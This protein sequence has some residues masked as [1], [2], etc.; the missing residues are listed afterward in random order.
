LEDRTVA[1]NDPDIASQPVPGV[2]AI[3]ASA[4]GVEALQRFARGLRADYPAPIL[5]VQH[6]GPHPSIL[7]EL[8]TRAG[9]PAARH[10]IDGERLQPARIYVAPPDHHMI[11]SN[12]RVRLSHGPKENHTRPAIDPLF[13]SVA[14]GYGPSAIGIVL[15]GWGDDGTAGL[16]AI[17]ACGG[18]AFVQNPADAEHP[19]MPMSALQYVDVDHTFDVNDLGRDLEAVL[20]RP[21]PP[22]AGLPDQLI[23]EH[24]TFLSKGDPMEHLSA[25]GSPSR[26][27][28]P[29]CNGGLWE[30]ADTHPRRFRCHTG[31]AFSL[32][33]LQAAQAESTD[34]ALWNAFRGLEEKEMLLRQ[35]A[36]Q[37]LEEGDP[38]QA[39]RTEVLAHVVRRHAAT[40]RDLIEREDPDPAQEQSG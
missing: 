16:Q 9:G 2:V 36:E 12:H 5:V 25:I 23:H 15:T 33:S 24:E 17:K 6:I 27:V 11:V 7:P 20:A 31:H 13:R 14:L 3:G 1:S 19:S 26:F 34:T 18:L 37:H 39:A 32:R 38:A 40:L 28:C 8:M 35:V 21:V 29:E 4:G 22:P 10:A 30:L